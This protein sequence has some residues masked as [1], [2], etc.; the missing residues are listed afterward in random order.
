MIRGY[1]DLLVGTLAAMMGV[2]LVFC[3]VLN[4]EWYYSLRTARWLQKM[5]GRNGARFVHT[6]LGLSI[7]AMGVAIALGYRWTLIGPGD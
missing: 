4:W 7:V 6:L 5:L 2:V 3:A 1:E